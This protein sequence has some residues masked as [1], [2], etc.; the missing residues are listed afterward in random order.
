MGAGWQ[1]VYGGGGGAKLLE[2][3]GRLV[4]HPPCRYKRPGLWGLSTEI[5]G[6]KKARLH[7]YHFK[8]LWKSRMGDGAGAREGWGSV[9]AEAQV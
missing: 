1:V 5:G 6:R 2:K 4:P 3:R 9:T 7:P 8:E